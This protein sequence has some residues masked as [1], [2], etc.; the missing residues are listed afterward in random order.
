[1]LCIAMWPNNIA[2]TTTITT[3]KGKFYDNAA[4][5]SL[6]EAGMGE[7]MYLRTILLHVLQ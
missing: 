3:R 4:I 1:M 2:A 6:T 7:T 5:L